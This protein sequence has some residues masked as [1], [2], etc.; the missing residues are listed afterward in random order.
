MLSREICKRCVDVWARAKRMD[1]MFHWNAGDDG[2]WKKGTVLCPFRDNLKKIVQ[3]SRPPPFCQKTFEQSV[4]SGM[5]NK[6]G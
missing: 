4:Y 3:I 6:N 5:R 2:R 1:S